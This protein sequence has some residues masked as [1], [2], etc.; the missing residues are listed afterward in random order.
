MD[1]DLFKLITRRYLAWGVGGSFAVT[2]CFVTIYG[3]LTAQTEFVAGGLSIA[4]TS[5]GFVLGYYFAKKTN[6]E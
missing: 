1:N 2:A 3:A 6:E 4:S 5:I